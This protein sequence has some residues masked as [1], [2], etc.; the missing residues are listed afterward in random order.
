MAWL[1]VYFN[2][3]H[4]YIVFG[5]WGIGSNRMQQCYWTPWWIYKRSCFWSKKLYLVYYVY[6]AVMRC[7]KCV[8][9]P[10]SRDGT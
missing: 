8:T 10:M 6:K 5:R 1:A 4:W 2:N 9:V 3:S 7:C